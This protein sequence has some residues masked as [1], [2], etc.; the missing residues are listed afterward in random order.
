MYFVML[1]IELMVFDHIDGVLIKI[2]KILIE[3]FFRHPYYIYIY[4]YPLLLYKQTI[5]DHNTGSCFDNK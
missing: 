4:I 3:R 1:L 2:G 5:V